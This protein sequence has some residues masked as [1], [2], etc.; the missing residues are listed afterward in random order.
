MPMLSVLITIRNTGSSPTPAQEHESR[1]EQDAQLMRAGINVVRMG[2]FPGGFA[3][4]R[5]ANTTTWLRRAMDV[6]AK[7][8]KVVL[9]PTA[10]PP[11]W[12]A[13]MHRNPAGR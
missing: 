12:L 6:M 9:E 7:Q 11:I 2:E 10:A 1:W 3:R 13:K 5:K 4:R 8:V